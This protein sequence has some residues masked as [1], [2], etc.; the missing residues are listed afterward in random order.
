V[1]LFTMQHYK[2]LQQRGIEAQFPPLLAASLFNEVY[3][4]G[5]IQVAQA[6]SLGLL[7]VI[8]LKIPTATLATYPA[9]RQAFMVPPD[10]PLKTGMAE[11][12]NQKVLGR[13]AVF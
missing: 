7:R 3:A 12:K 8:D 13:P 4:P 11:L 6:G 2:L 1:V 9:Q 5:R 10:S